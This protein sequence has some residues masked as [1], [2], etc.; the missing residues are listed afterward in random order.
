M[1]AAD[2]G[3]HLRLE[4]EPALAGVERLVL[5]GSGLA[6]PG[7]RVSGGRLSRLVGA[8][9][10]F[11]PRGTPQPPFAVAPDLAGAEFGSCEHCYREERLD[12]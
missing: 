5:R 12:R 8:T 11:A 9:G 4:H 7:H 3:R 1:G 2:R 6:A 10:F